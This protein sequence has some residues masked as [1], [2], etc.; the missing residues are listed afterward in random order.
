MELKQLTYFLTVADCLSFSRAADKLYISQPALSYQI[1]ELERELGAELFL[2][3][4]RSVALTLTGR[5]LVAPARRMLETSTEIH[6]IAR[7][8]QDDTGFFQRLCVYF[9]EGLAHQV[10][11]GVTRALGQF[12]ATHEKVDFSLHRANTEECLEKLQQGEMDVAILTRYYNEI[13]PAKLEEQTLFTDRLVAVV[14][15]RAKAMGLNSCSAVF[16]RYELGHVTGMPRIHSRVL[17]YLRDVGL[18]PTVHPVD[19]LNSAFAYLYAGRM[20]LVLPRQYVLA[21]NDPELDTV[22]LPGKAMEL[23]CCAVWN[24][25]ND[26]PV[27]SELLETWRTRL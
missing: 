3:D 13:L 22:E 11:S 8:R 24:T 14:P 9:E 20:A 25:N 21:H 18:K 19:D 5:R 12:I 4:K 23:R 2:R 17:K 26:L 1:S 7:R 16:Q 27:L 15:K 10:C 6:K